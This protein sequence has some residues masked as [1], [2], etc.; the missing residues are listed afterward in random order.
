MIFVTGGAGFIG[1]NFVVDW[2][3]NPATAAAESVLVIDALTYAYR[4]SGIGSG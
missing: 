2:I 1:A 3:E 4:Q